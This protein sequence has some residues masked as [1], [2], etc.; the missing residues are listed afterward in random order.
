MD[1]TDAFWILLLHSGYHPPTLYSTLGQLLLWRT[2]NLYHI[3]PFQASYSLNLVNQPI[4]FIFSQKLTVNLTYLWNGRTRVF[5]ENAQERNENFV[6]DGG[7]NVK[8]LR[9]TFIVI[10]IYTYMI[11]PGGPMWFSWEKNLQLLLRKCRKVNLW[12]RFFKIAA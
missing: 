5:K 7:I 1:A 8:I 9:Q 2:D 4:Y 6:T 3:Q 12:C 10:I 11:F